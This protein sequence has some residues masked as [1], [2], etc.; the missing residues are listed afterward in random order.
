MG[1]KQTWKD[2]FIPQNPQ[3]YFGGSVDKITYRSSWEW[4]FMRYCDL[5]PYV[6]GWSSET[7]DIPYFNPY[8]NRQTVYIPDFVLVY[9]DRSG[10]KIAEM[11]EIKPA[12]EVPFLKEGQA[13]KSK[14]DK[15]A[16]ALNM[17]KWQAATKFCLKRGIKFRVMTEHDLFGSA[18]PPKG[19][20]K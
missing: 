12:K 5:N 7:C 4:T 16:Q 19:K 20:K 13:T 1:R 3:K 14:K 9:V 6:L 8:A 15:A 2:K 17:V 18:G 10:K 11:I